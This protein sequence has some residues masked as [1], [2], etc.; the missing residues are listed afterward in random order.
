M[1]TTAIYMGKGAF[2]ALEA[3]SEYAYQDLADS[4]GGQI[5]IMQQIDYLAAYMDLC[6]KDVEVYPGVV[7]YELCGSL[8][9]FAVTHNLDWELCCEE[10]DEQIKEWLK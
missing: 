5:G 4:F 3:L 9:E 10:I 6:L 8:G 1:T 2:D 7:E